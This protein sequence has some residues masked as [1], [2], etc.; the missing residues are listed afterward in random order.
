MT[1]V[2]SSTPA[3]G[4]AGPWALEPVTARDVPR[5]ALSSSRE[6]EAAGR[7]PG[8]AGRRVTA[9]ARLV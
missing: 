1:D 4:G 2:S 6:F 5:P 3:V 7:R 9:G 8:I